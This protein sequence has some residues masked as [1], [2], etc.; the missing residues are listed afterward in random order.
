[1]AKRSSS[2]SNRLDGQQDV[3]A[4]RALYA[5]QFGEPLSEDDLDEF[6]ES[7]RLQGFF[8]PEAGTTFTPDLSPSKSEARPQRGSAGG[9]QSILHWRK[10]LWDP[11]RLFT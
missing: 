11:D 9:S 3:E 6:V 8:H 5:E 10:S 1:M 2:C 4:L 7:A